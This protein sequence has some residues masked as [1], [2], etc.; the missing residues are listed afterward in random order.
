[1]PEHFEWLHQEKGQGFGRASARSPFLLGLNTFCI[2]AD[3]TGELVRARARNPWIDLPNCPELISQGLFRLHGG[4]ALQL[5]QKGYCLLR[6][7]DPHWPDLIDAAL[8]QLDLAMDLEEWRIG[9][10]GCS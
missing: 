4:R 8:S 10:D 7:V 9:P 2:L 6:P 3:K 1:M 5:H